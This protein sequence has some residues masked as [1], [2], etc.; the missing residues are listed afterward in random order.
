MHLADSFLCCRLWTCVCW[1]IYPPAT[2]RAVLD[3]NLLN[4]DSF[5]YE[6]SPELLRFR[7]AAPSIELLTDWYRSRAEDIEQNSRQVITADRRKA[8][9]PA[10]PGLQRWGSLTCLYC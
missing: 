6:E 1:C 2:L 5:L 8:G 3:Q 4:N 9:S 10:A 7:A